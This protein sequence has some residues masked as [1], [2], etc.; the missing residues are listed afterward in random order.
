MAGTGGRFIDRGVEEARSIEHARENGHEYV[1][2]IPISLQ[3]TVTLSDITFPP[4]NWLI[5]DL[6]R[7]P[8]LAILAGKPGKGKSWLAM[9]LAY[10]VARGIELWGRFPVT[11][12]AV[13]YL[14]NEATDA[15]IQARL[16][17]TRQDDG[18]EGAGQFLLPLGEDRGKLQPFDKGGL[19]QL[20]AWLGA[21]PHVRLVVVDIWA[22]MAPR[23]TARMQGNAYFQDYEMIRPLKELT[24]RRNICLLLVHHF[25]KGESTDDIDNVAGTTGFVGASDIRLLLIRANDSDEADLVVSGR[26]VRGCRLVIEQ[27]RETGVWVLK[28]DKREV[29]RGGTRAAILNAIADAGGESMT[30]R[31]I[32]SACG[33]SYDSVRVTLG[34]LVRE[35]LVM[36]ASRGHYR[37]AMPPTSDGPRYSAAEVS[38]GA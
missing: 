16:A 2:P 12:A 21:H 23:P 14:D 9:L 24:D 33:K 38:D 10:H 29:V 26:K 25:R 15:D 36:T 18:H 11:R 19:E 28:G 37:A 32:A 7:T 17:A 31:Q 27:Q 22:N 4:P 20:D 35:G 8:S 13:I 30:P 1:A 6:L 34:H 5:Q 3:D